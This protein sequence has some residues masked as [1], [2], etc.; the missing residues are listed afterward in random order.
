MTFEDTTLEAW[1]RVLAVNQTAVFIG[2][3]HA[4]HALIEAAQQGHDPSI[5]ILASVCST[6]GGHGELPSYYA[7][8]GAVIQM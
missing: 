8:K 4:K 2:C 6:T 1:Q 3:K 7:T 5:V